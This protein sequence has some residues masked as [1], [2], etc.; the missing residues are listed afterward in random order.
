M[1]K[2]T[3]ETDSKRITKRAASGK[4]ATKSTVSRKSTS[5]TKVSKSNSAK[6]TL[7]N[8]STKNNNSKAKQKSATKVNS[9]K[10]MT[11]KSRNTSKEITNSKRTKKPEIIEYYDLPYRYN[12]TVVKILAQ[13]P[14]TLFVYWDIADS[15]RKEYEKRFGENF[16]EIT[17]PVLIVHNRTMN[18]S[19]EIEI[20]DFANC[21][22]FTVADS[23]CNYEIELGRRLKSPSAQIPE[24]YIGITSSNV[25]ETPN[26]HI[27]FEK[28]QKILFFRNVKTSQD[29]EKDISQ[30]E[31]MKYAGRIYNIYDVY[32]KIYSFEELLDI[33]K[34]PSSS[35]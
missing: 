35:F 11:K 25:I 19:F 18:Y 17:V 3:K 27:L 30:F 4:G 15:D 24:N 12:Q 6:K 7:E 16:F 9:K 20:N 31:L 8:K 26:N 21:W 5:N 10:S 23:K 32:K 29:V 14:T 33:E 22:Y 1:Q 34:N 13:T 28:N 2:N